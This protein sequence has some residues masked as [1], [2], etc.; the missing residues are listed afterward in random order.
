MDLFIESD[1]NTKKDSIKNQLIDIKRG[2][3]YRKWLETEKENLD[4]VDLRHK[5]F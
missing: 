3:V 2:E 1:Y 5:V 4:I